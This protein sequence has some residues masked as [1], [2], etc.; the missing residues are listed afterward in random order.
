MSNVAQAKRHRRS[1][2]YLVG[3]D[4]L[5]KIGTSENVYHRLAALRSSSPVHVDLIAYFDGGYGTEQWLHGR[6]D[7]YRVHHEWFRRSGEFDRWVDS[8]REMMSNGTLTRSSALR[9]AGAVIADEPPTPTVRSAWEPSPPK[10]PWLVM[11]EAKR[12][13]SKLTR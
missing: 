10:K 1:V 6:F 3:Y 13:A 7:A 12:V 9:S 4:Y 2:V 5:V 8:V 11:L